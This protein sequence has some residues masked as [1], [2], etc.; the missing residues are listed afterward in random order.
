MDIVR[1]LAAVKVLVTK[2]D[3][4]KVRDSSNDRAFDKSDGERATM[5][6]RKKDKLNCNYC[7]EP[8]HFVA[9]CTTEL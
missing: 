7:G 4:V 9:D 8:G 2:P 5:W 3:A 1:S 6:A